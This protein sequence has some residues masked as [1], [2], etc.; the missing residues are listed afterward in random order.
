[1]G[2]NDNELQFLFAN[3]VQFSLDVYFFILSTIY[4]FLF[5]L[6]LVFFP[7]CFDNKFSS[8]YLANTEPKSFWGSNEER[9]TSHYTQCT[10]LVSIAT[11]YANGE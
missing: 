8:W 3:A 10:S 4:T 2:Y 11:K 1:M 9:K 7:R 5:T 6:A